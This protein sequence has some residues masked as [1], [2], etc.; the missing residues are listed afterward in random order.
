MNDETDTTEVPLAQLQRPQGPQHLW[1]HQESR[2]QLQHKA[3]RQQQ[4]RQTLCSS[5]IATQKIHREVH[6]QSPSSTRA[7]TTT[8]PSVPTTFPPKNVCADSHAAT[9]ST[10]PVGSTMKKQCGALGRAEGDYR[11]Q[12]AVE[13]AQSFQFGTTW[14]R[15]LAHNKLEAKLL[16]TC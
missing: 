1:T 6:R 4:A 16:R 12:T 7:L 13:Q 14:M 8:V 11:A 15:T 2:L 9:C 5:S 3:L 10:R